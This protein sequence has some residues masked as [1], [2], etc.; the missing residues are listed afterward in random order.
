MSFYVSFSFPS[1]FFKKDTNKKN[2]QKKSKKEKNIFKKIQNSNFTKIILEL[3][4]FKIVLNLR[5]L[6]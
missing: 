6:F 4:I 1:P 3:F 5:F 2:R